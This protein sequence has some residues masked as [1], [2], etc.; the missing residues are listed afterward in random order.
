MGVPEF[1][2]VDFPL[3]GFVSKEKTIGVSRMKEK[4]KLVYL[5]ERQRE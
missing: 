3:R 2:V 1:P 5:G 4:I